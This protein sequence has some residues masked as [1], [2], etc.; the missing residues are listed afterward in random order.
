MELS[1]VERLIL[2]NQFRILE[3]IDPDEARDSQMALE[4]LRNGYTLD[5]ESLVSH[6]D[7]EVSEATCR[8]VRDILDLY[9]ALKKALREL[10]EGTLTEKEATFKGFD[11][12]EETEHYSYVLFLIEVQRKWGESATAE[13]NSHCPMLERY[14]P[15]LEQ[16]KRCPKKWD[17]TAEDI[18]RILETERRRR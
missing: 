14:R 7:K 10:P 16:W 13:L 6:F 9:R 18:G 17:L 15:M 1:K 4:I 3:K 11:G 8:E 5:Y 12:N 2:A